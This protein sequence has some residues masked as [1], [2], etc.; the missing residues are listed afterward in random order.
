MA[1]PLTRLK[2]WTCPTRESGGAKLECVAGDEI[3][4][5]PF[6][7]PGNRERRGE[8]GTRDSKDGPNAGPLTVCALARAEPAAGKTPRR[9]QPRR[10]SIKPDTVLPVGGRDEAQAN[11]EGG[12]P[13]RG[14]AGSPVPQRPQGSG[15]SP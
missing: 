11:V 6:G 1:Q 2:R 4:G 12:R 14:N 10:G 9:D 8:L 5:E 15:G 13:F 3:P 7:A